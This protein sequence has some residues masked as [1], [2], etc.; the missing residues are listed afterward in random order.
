MDATLVRGV[1][2]PAVMRLAGRA[3]W[4]APG[5][6]GGTRP[7]RERSAAGGG[8]PREGRAAAAGAEPAAGVEG[9]A[10]GGP[11]QGPGQDAGQAER[12]SSAAF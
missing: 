5:Q 4:W 10:A 12:K 1:L 3:N 8:T 6:Q 2:V 9:E 11:F 7:T